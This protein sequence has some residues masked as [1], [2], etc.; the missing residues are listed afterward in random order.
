MQQHKGQQA[1]RAASHVLPPMCSRHPQLDMESMLP[2]GTLLC[3][4]GDVVNIAGLC[5]KGG[6][7]RI[8]SLLTAWHCTAARQHG[9][10]EACLPAVLA[11]SSRMGTQQNMIR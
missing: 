2:Q 7:V 5:S 3:Q 10:L 8:W 9:L 11:K 6:K 1:G 4:P